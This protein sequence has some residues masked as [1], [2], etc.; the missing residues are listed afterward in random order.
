MI[1]HGNL[2]S[3]EAVIK[4]AF[5]HDRDSTVVGWL[6]LYHDMGLIGNVIQPLYVGS[7]AILMPPLRLSR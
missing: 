6:P 3:N 4:S 5:G 2:L 7:T 1:S